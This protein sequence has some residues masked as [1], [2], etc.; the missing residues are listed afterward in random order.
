MVKIKERLSDFDFATN[1]KILHDEIL[2]QSASLMQRGQT[3]QSG[4]QTEE[5]TEKLMYIC[6]LQQAHQEQQLLAA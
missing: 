5:L 2:L 4:L 1:V 6:Q 3:G